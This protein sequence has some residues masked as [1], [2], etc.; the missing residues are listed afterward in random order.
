MKFFKILASIGIAV[1]EII[2]VIVICIALDFVM[3]LIPAIAKIILG[4]IVVLALIV[5]FIAKIYDDI[6]N[7]TGG[8]HQ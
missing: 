5:L 8:D 3:G 2:L 4:T 6:F 7:K 1:I